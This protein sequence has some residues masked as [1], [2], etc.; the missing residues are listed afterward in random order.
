MEFMIDPC[1]IER[2][3]ADYRNQIGDILKSKIGKGPFEIQIRMEH[4]QNIHCTIEWDGHLFWTGVHTDRS[5]RKCPYR[6]DLDAVE[7]AL[8]ALM[9]D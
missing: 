4:N 9:E 1:R 7:Q 6:W 2:D 3:Y 8:D 5:V